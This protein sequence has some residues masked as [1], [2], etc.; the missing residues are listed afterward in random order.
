[1]PPLYPCP[2]CGYHTLTVKPPE[3]YLICPICCWEDDGDVRRKFGDLVSRSNKVYLRE[4]QRNFI[5]FGACEREWLD[6][7]RK[8]TVD[9]FRDPNWQPLDMVLEQRRVALIEKITLAFQKTQ[10]EEGVTLHQARAL[11]DYEDPQQARQI[12]RHLKWQ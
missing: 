12:D 6:W 3:T 5:K 10:L 1:M 9:D 2:C 7:V 8:P 11:D 4:A